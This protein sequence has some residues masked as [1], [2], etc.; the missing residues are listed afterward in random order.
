MQEV[1]VLLATYNGE[2]YLREFLD[3]LAA[4]EDVNIHLLVSDDGS[5]DSTLQIVD[6]YKPKFQKLSVLE[7]PRSGPMSNFFHL[8]RASKADFIA[9]ADQDDIWKVDHLKKSIKRIGNVDLPS[10]TF[11]AVEEFDHDSKNIRIWPSNYSGPKFPSIIFENTARGCTV[12]INAHARELINLKEPKN[13][14]MHDW[15]ILLLVQLYGVVSFEPCPEIEYRLHSQNFIGLPK[16][17]NVAFLKT[18]KTGRW[19][20]L[21][22]FRELLDY[23]QTNFQITDDFNIK[24]FAMNLEGHLIQRLRKVIFASGTRYRRSF[25]DELKLRFGLIFLKTLDRQG[26]R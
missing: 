20:P 13:A 19:L 24:L 12:V 11:T 21:A 17:R 7:G 14:I 2:L 1:D 4:Q 26:T 5:T 16:N 23:P 3:S 18:L 10:M 25:S 9:F 22:Q 15:W 6:S 8:L